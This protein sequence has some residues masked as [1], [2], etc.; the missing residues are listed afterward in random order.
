MARRSYTAGTPKLCAQAM[1][2]L[3]GGPILVVLY[4]HDGNST[5][6]VSESWPDAK[7]QCDLWVA[8]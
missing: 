6:K 5:E 3:T 4:D 8:Q 7:M 2:E 1:Q